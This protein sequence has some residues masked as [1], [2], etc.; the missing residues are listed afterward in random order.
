V[1]SVNPRGQGRTARFWADSLRAWQRLPQPGRN[2]L[3]LV[4]HF[5]NATAPYVT[6]IP[7]KKKFD[8]QLETAVPAPYKFC[9]GAHNTVRTRPQWWDRSEDDALITAKRKPMDE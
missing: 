7:D 3:L 1:H 6:A 5:A 9:A 8:A 2:L 4:I